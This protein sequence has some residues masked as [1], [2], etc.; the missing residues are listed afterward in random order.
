MKLYFNG[1]S[2]TH[3]DELTSP[4]KDAWPMLVS[5][6]LNAICTND[7]VSG[8]TNGRTLYLTL[9]QAEQHDFVFVAWTYYHRFTEYNPVDNFEI[10]FTPQ[11]N[12]DPE[13]HDSDD[14]KKNFS[15]Y[16]QH[17]ETFY[18]YWFNE[19]YEF[20][21]WL[22]QIVL[23]QSFFRARNKPYIMLNTVDNHLSRWSQPWDT[24]NEAC[25]DLISFFD[26]VDD[27]QLH[28]QHQQIQYLI[29]LIDRTCFI[30]WGSWC[31]KDLC[32]THLCGPRGHILESGHSAVADR[33][34]DHY[35]THT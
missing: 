5:S 30:D 1:C 20:K 10:N 7:A 18:K 12:L 33:V 16:K 15:K 34:L 14:L 25:R 26:R 11:L 24:F 4:E 23:L 28:N 9:S 21:K 32:S 35:N 13:L 8:G 3:R 17:G 2:F 22:Q 6:H 27:Y 19:L 29:S 31:I